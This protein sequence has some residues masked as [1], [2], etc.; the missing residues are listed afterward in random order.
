MLPLQNRGYFSNVNTIFIFTVWSDPKGWCWHFQGQRIR[1]D[2]SI[3]SQFTS[4][5]NIVCCSWT[6]YF[7]YLLSHFLT[8]HTVLMLGCSTNFWSEMK[9]LL[10]WL[11][12]RDR[13][14]PRCTCQHTADVVLKK[15]PWDVLNIWVMMDTFF[16]YWKTGEGAAVFIP[17]FC[18]LHFKDYE[19][20]GCT[21]GK[22]KFWWGMFG[23]AV[24]FWRMM[25][26][27][28]KDLLIR[29]NHAY[30]TKQFE[31]WGLEDLIWVCM[32]WLPQQL[33]KELMW[34]H[35]HFQIEECYWQ[36][37]ISLNQD[38]P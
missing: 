6:V 7:T 27:K 32:L 4:S 25:H 19:L 22:N 2:L 21:W 33:G 9:A 1:Q 38:H 15:N 12:M 34:K 23:C 35:S 3:I 5:W 31:N 24:L 18:F 13:K 11:S 10:G 14:L 37:I 20:S 29:N 36:V 28:A 17:Q 8:T 30:F 16:F 26:F